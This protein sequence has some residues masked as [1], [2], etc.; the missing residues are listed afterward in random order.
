MIAR[1]D[2]A[3]PKRVS[4]LPF[5]DGSRAVRQ[6]NV[7]VYRANAA[8]VNSALAGLPVDPGCFTCAA[9]PLAPGGR[10]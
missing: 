1:A 9:A 10:R 3:D 2:A 4:A 5:D 7:T 6:A 8:R